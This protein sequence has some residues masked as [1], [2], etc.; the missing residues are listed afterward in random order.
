M[1]KFLEEE[2]KNIHH[3]HTDYKTNNC[4]ETVLSLCI[5]LFKENRYEDLMNYL[6]ILLYWASHTIVSITLNN[7]ILFMIVIALD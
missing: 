5:G 7:E 1:A 6:I 3:H 4:F 2:K